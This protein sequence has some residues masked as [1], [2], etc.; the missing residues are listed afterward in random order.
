[1]ATLNSLQ[2]TSSNTVQS[3]FQSVFQKTVSGQFLELDTLTDGTPFASFDYDFRSDGTLRRENAITLPGDSK[4][5]RYTDIGSYVISGQKV[6]V[7]IQGRNDT[8][9]FTLDGNG[10]LISS[11]GKRLKRQ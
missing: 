2:N 4:V 11:D 1:M 8:I 6:V 7:T 9:E 5:S 3:T 10:D